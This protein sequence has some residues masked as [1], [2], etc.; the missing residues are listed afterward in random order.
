MSNDNI[1]VKFGCSMFSSMFATSIVHPC[2]VIKVSKQLNYPIKYN[3][4]QL[5]RGYFIGLFRQATYSTPNMVIYSYLMD[6]YKQKYNSEP[7]YYYKSA[8]GFLSGALSGLTGNPS[9][10]MFIKTLKENKSIRQTYNEIV[11][12][13]GYGHFLNGYK[14]AMIR[15]AI[16]NSSRLSLYS[17]SKGYFISHYPELSGSSSLHFMSAAVGTISAIIISNPIDVIKARVQKD[18]TMNISQMVKHTYI[19][20]GFGGFYKGLIPSISKSFP[21]SVIA[22][23]M[24]EKTT[25]LITGKDAL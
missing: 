5:Y 21:H 20:E 4:S 23:V 3:I 19:N 24:L 9:E 8:F 12:N 16:Y 14:A 10:V 6:N 25:Q 13:Y 1:Y 7:E 11:S 22:F 2:D 18:K 15:S 17:E